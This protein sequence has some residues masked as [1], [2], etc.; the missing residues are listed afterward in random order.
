[1]SSI[2]SREIQIPSGV[3]I[4]FEGCVLRT[5]GNKGVN[6][7]LLPSLVLVKKGDNT[8]LL[9]INESSNFCL[10]ETSVALIKNA[11][12]D[13]NDGVVVKIKMIG[14]GFKAKVQGKF[15]SVF[16]GYSH[17]IFFL[18]PESINVSVQ[19]DIEITIA[20]CDRQKVM[21]FAKTIHDVR[22][23]EPYK[24]KGIFI[25]DEKVVRK[26]GKKK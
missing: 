8:L 7:V 20:G 17:D 19:N 25:D 5:S 9:S 18:I 14:V 2:L 1:M 13:A 6:E 4:D 12:A 24:G 21:L 11:I 15:L 26:E 16:V 10:L 23:P 22:K 3:S